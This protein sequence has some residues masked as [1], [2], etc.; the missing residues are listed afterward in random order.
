IP[1]IWSFGLAFFRPRPFQRPGIPNKW[2]RLI[3]EHHALQGYN[4]HRNLETGLQNLSTTRH[5]VQTAQAPQPIVGE[6][7]PVGITP[8]HQLPWYRY[9]NPRVGLEKQS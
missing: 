8:E 7:F 2:L 5:H 4:P 1:C 3:N 9:Y 6:D